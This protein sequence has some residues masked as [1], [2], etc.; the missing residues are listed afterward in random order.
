V[1]I[2]CS[3]LLSYEKTR[4]I[5]KNNREDKII[6]IHAVIFDPGGVIAVLFLNA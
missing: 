1:S 3:L 6:S 2:G 4:F 5:E